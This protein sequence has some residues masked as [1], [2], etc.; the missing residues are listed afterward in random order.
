MA[1]QRG[2]LAK[3]A[4]GTLLRQ[5][6]QQSRPASSSS[7]RWLG[8]DSDHST[9]HEKQAIDWQQDGI[10]ISLYDGTLLQTA[11]VNHRQNVFGCFSAVQGGL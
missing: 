1:G 9:T 8:L 7:S 6:G 3:F 5:V 4:L 10:V 11:H 2:M